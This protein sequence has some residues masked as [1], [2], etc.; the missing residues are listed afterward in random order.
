[1]CVSGCTNKE[2]SE[3]YIT[4]EIISY[5][6]YEELSGYKDYKIGDGIE[7][8]QLIKLLPIE[9]YIERVFTSTSGGT[10]DM[11]VYYIVDD[12]EGSL[13]TD[14][15]IDK[16]ILFNATML[17]AII[18]NVDEITFNISGEKELDYVFKR[19]YVEGLY[20]YELHELLQDKEVWID[21]LIDPI[22]AGTYVMSEEVKISQ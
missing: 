20:P 14:E 9:Y 17:F 4:N 2:G 8:V 5:D 3:A 1:M 6:T 18:E 12:Q 15:T 13:W 11:K 21:K 19:E 7:D 10:Y 16:K 22:I